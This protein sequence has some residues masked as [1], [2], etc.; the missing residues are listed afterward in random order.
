MKFILRFGALL[1]SATAVLG[2]CPRITSLQTRFEVAPG[3]QAVLRVQAAGTNLQYR[4]YRGPSGDMHSPQVMGDAPVFWT[5]L[6]SIQIEYWVQVSTGTCSVDSP[7]VTIVATQATPAQIMAQ[8]GD[9]VVPRGMQARLFV[10]AVGQP[11]LDMQW[12]VGNTGNTNVPVAGA[13]N[14]LFISPPLTNAASYW[15]RVLNSFGQADSTAIAIDVRDTTVTA[16]T[17]A[18]GH[19]VVELKGPPSWWYYFQVSHDL[20]TW[21]TATNVFGFQLDTNG[22]AIVDIPIGELPAAFYRAGASR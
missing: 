19:L 6:V 15:V 7:T 16:S 5:E 12:Y 14:A 13:T 11:P 10:T 18:N 22:A 21:E 8:Y 2:Q 17:V 9:P 20:K 3:Q 1:S 4:W